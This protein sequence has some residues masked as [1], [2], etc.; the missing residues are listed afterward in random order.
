MSD[1]T[2]FILVASADA[3][4]DEEFARF[5]AEHAP[6]AL[7]LHGDLLTISREAL[8][9]LRQHTAVMIDKPDMIGRMSVD[10]VH[11][12][13]HGSLKELRKKFSALNLGSGGH[14]SKHSAMEAGEDGADY[15]AFGSLFA[16]AG[17]FD[18]TLE[19]AAWWADVMTTPSVIRVEDVATLEAALAAGLDFVAFD[20]QNRD[21]FKTFLS[22]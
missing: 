7:I 10:G 19:L 2:P 21:S 4:K 6:S 11:M 8:L 3:V 5:V 16:K 22:R 17:D 1:Q 13:A 18:K 9:V 12:E 15:V 20:W 14:A